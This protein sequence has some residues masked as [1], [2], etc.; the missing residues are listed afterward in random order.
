MWSDP[1][2]LGV[3][4]LIILPLSFGLNAWL[5]HHWLRRIEEKTDRVWESLTD[6]NSGVYIRLARLEAEAHYDG[7]DRRRPDRGGNHVA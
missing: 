7:P 1:E 4:A 5:M 3:L 6:A 2:K